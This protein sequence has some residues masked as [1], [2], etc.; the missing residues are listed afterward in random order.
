MN[1][2]VQACGLVL[3]LILIYFFLRHETVGLFSERLFKMSLVV[4]TVCIILDI[5]SVIAVVASEVIPGFLVTIACKLYLVS[6]VTVAF[7]AFLYTSNDIR[8]LRENESFNMALKIFLAISAFFVVMLP[9]NTYRDGQYAYS[10]GLSVAVTFFISALFLLGALVLTFAQ[11]RYMNKDR[12]NAIRAWM[13]LE[14]LAMGVQIIFPH[15]LLVGFGSSVGL[16]I[17]YCELES[18]EVYIDRATGVFSYDTLILYLKQLFSEGHKFVGIMVCMEDEWKMENE[19]ESRILLEISEYLHSF[20]GA[21]LFRCSGHDFLLIYDSGEAS[22]DQIESTI[23]LDVIKTRFRQPFDQNMVIDARFLYLP[24]P[25]IATD[26][27][28]Y[29]E[30]CRL[31]QDEMGRDTVSMTLDEDAGRHIRE[32]RAI[33]SEILNALAEDR[34]E[35]HFQ[36]IYSFRDR[37]FV[38]AEALA[39][40][41]NSEGKL[42]MPGLFIPVAEEYGLIDRI[43]EKV[44]EITCRTFRNNNLLEKGIHYLEVNLSVAQCEDRRLS[45]I[46]NGIMKREQVDPR[47]INLEITES[48]TLHYRN[49]LLENMNLLSDLGCSFSLDDFGTGESN[50]NYIVDMPVQIV[51]FDRDMV[52]N[53]FRNDRAKI[54][55]RATVS[56]IKTMGLKIVAEGVET[57][58]Q[59]DAMEELGVDYIQGYYFSKPLQEKDF[60]RFIETNNRVA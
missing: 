31:Y 7:M 1:V 43:G 20:P 46:Y 37:M 30:I 6:L 29:L 3:D 24:D 13:A 26:C 27:D 2:D 45:D 16:V 18:P 33:R 35:V 48:S 55:M 47:Y 21:K 58:E 60:L 38:S 8:H 34:I 50:L 51:K 12:R 19:Q 42:I 11:G 22:R 41:V 49:I 17:L 59:L 32:Q 52:Q 39:R 53:Y 14:L 54:V 25:H 10:Q 56:M 5:L 44:F 15:I 23:N 36:P 40:I 28:E 4:S 57:K 9:I